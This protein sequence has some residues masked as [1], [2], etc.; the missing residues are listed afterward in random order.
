MVCHAGNGTIY[1]AL[2]RGIPMVLIPS[3]FEQEWNAHRIVKLQL[4]EIHRPEA[5]IEDFVIKC[6]RQLLSQQSTAR[7][8]MMN[9]LMNAAY[10]PLDSF[11]AD[12]NN[13][14]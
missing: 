4:G 9:E 1:Q 8:E 12:I 5:G 10:T 13:N 11:F 3:F 7:I 6:K 14:L 2:M